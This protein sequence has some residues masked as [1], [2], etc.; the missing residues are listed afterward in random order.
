MGLT[1]D[2]VSDD[3]DLMWMMCVFLTL[4][5]IP[6]EFADEMG[7]PLHNGNEKMEK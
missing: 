2:A 5:L 1:T 3:I 6:G 7:E 4:D